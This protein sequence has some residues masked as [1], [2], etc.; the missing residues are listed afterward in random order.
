M[1]DDD[2][3]RDGDD[4]KIDDTLLAKATLSIVIPARDTQ[5]DSSLQNIHLGTRVLGEQWIGDIA[6]GAEITSSKLLLSE[7]DLVEALGPDLTLS[8]TSL[9]ENAAGAVIGTLTTQDPDAGDS[10]S[11]TV[12]DARFEVVA[13]QLKLKD[14]VS[15]DHEAEPSLTLEVTA[16]DQGGL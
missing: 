6:L 16:T 10:H 7:V 3:A 5:F 8:A 9:A 12:S 11:Y 14:G 4:A 13:G 15:L 2:P 1:S